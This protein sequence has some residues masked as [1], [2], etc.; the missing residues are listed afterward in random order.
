MGS[1]PTQTMTF[2][3]HQYLHVC[4]CVSLWGPLWGY[5]VYG[6]EDLYGKLMKIMYI[7]TQKVGD[8]IVK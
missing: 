7:E 4:D 3:I 8:Q 2:N 6:V 1:D 5:S